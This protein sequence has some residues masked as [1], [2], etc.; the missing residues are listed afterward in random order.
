MVGLATQGPKATTQ[1]GLNIKTPARR[2][3][4]VVCPGPVASLTK[5]SLSLEGA[6]LLASKMTSP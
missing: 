1:D 6:C 2:S 4:Q 3:W 5:V